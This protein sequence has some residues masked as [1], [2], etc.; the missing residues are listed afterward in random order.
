MESLNSKDS[1][2]QSEVESL[3]SKDTTHQSE[4]ESLNSKDTSYKKRKDGHY[5]TYSLNSKDTVHNTRLKL[6]LQHIPYW[7][8]A[9]LEAK[10][11]QNETELPYLG[12]GSPGC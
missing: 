7:I 6:N 2:H 4:V 1:T 12:L 9:H 8:S 10:Q 11:S 5:N 3:N